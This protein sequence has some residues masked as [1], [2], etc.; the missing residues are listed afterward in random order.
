MCRREA[1][2][3]D[4]HVGGVADD[5]RSI[6]DADRR[7]ISDLEYAEPDEVFEQGLPEFLAATSHRCAQA[8]VAVNQQYALA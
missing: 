5:Q 7:A 1:A 3:G 2:P 6:G 4:Q 8:S